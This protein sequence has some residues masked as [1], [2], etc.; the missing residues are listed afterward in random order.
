MCAVLSVLT[1]DSKLPDLSY[2]CCQ[3]DPFSAKTYPTKPTNSLC[4][5][6][7]NNSMKRTCSF[8]KNLFISN[9]SLKIE[10]LEYWKIL[11]EKR[12]HFIQTSEICC[13]LLTINFPLLLTA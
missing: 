6:I 9:S 5:K 10:K 12:H 4:E 1:V 13:N 3:S 11:L 8:H 2:T 7:C